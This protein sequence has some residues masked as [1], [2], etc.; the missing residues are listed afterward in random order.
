[1]EVVR[2]LIK[3]GADVTAQT[4]GDSTPLF[5]GLSS[6]HCLLAW[7]LIRDSASTGT[8]TLV[9]YGWTW[10]FAL[11]MELAQ[12]LIDHG[13]NVSGKNWDR[14]WTPLHLVSRESNVQFVRFLVE[15]GAD[16]TAQDE[17]GS[18]PLHLV[19]HR[20]DIARILVEHGADVTAHDK[21]GSTPL[22]SASFGGSVK[23]LMVVCCCSCITSQTC[24]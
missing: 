1:M 10:H 4:K 3:Q 20:V 9:M 11:R 14:G 6:G 15:H 8:E 5:D 13:A 22:Y 12:L 16:V 21:D 17:N 23:F 24:I 19:P 7:S 18:T 2:F